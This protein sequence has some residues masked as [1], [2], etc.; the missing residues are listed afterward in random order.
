MAEMGKVWA[1]S[2]SKQQAAAAARGA[3]RAVDGGPWASCR[4]YIIHA[5]SHF[6]GFPIRSGHIV[7]HLILLVPLLLLLLLLRHQRIGDHL[8]GARRAVGW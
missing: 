5:I 1:G 2:S 8:W 4:E 6:A 3:R 7:I